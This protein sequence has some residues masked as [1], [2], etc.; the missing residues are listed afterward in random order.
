[1][2]DFRTAYEEGIQE[3]ERAVAAKA[4]IEEVFR[5]LNRQLAEATDGRLH[6]CREQRTR[7]DSFALAAVEAFRMA[8][9]YRTPKYTA[10]VARVAVGDEE[11]SQVLAEWEQDA[12]GYP[13][14][15]ISSGDE[16]TCTDKEALEEGLADLL[17]TAEVGEKLLG[18]LRA[19][20]NTANTGT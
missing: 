4:E 10:L 17:R 12:Y 1:M 15:I 6:V 2:A 11:K 5:E 19:V 7:R 14:R 8:M 9:G 20:P 18:L 13:C 16:L 3:A